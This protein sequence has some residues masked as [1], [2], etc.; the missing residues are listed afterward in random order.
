MSIT[1]FI[2]AAVQN[3]PI[4]AQ[5]AFADAIQPKVDAAVSDM[6]DNVAQ[7]VFNQE[8]VDDQEFETEMEDQNDV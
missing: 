5:Q 7:S 1:D 3:K 6:Y 2:S 8:M 4:A